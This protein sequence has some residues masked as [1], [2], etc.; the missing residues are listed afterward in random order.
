MKKT[1]KI[2]YLLMLFSFLLTSC[3][4]DDESEN[5]V[6][7]F[8]VSTGNY[9]PLAVDNIWS[10]HNEIEGSLNEIRIVSTNQFDSY[11]YYEFTDTDPTP[12][13]IKQWF[14]KKGAVYFLKADDTSFSENNI[15]I[16]IKSYELPILKDNYEVNKY[17]TGSVS[18]KV[19][20]SGNGS[21]GTLPFKVDYSG[22]NY[23]KGAVVLKGINY[24]N[25]I[26]TKLNITI[27][28]N[29]QITNSSEENWFAENIGIIKTITINNGTQ[30]E[31]NIDSYAL[32]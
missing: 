16:N 22:V 17:W 29:G 24:P 31:K 14:G 23:Y 1:P 19:T 18:P 6:D 13:Q 26:K 15:F 30:I 7:S 28:A 25:V 11:T 10:Y 9:F 5:N 12:I 4:K 20:F 2:I 21:S 32:N 27:N 8:G 3:S